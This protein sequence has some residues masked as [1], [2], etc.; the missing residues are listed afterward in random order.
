[1]ASRHRDAYLEVMN[2][3]FE[4]YSKQMEPML[5]HVARSLPIEQ[6]EV[7]DPVAAKV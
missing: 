3:L 1:M 4:T 6:L 7:R 5:D 2:L